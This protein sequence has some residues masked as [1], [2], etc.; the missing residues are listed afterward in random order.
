MIYYP[1]E[2]VYGSR[3]TAV[4]FFMEGKNMERQNYI[5]LIRLKMEKVM[6]L[7]YSGGVLN[8]P[9]KLADFT[10]QVL[11][12]ADREYLLV[13]SVNIQCQPVALE[14]ISIGGIDSAIVSPREVF[15]H[16][17]MSNAA[18]IFLIHNHPSGE[19]RPSESDKAITERIRKA[20]ELLDIP[21]WDHVITGSKER[22]YSFKEQGEIFG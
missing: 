19:C 5:P 6:E 10:Q 4:P 12:D 3:V 7:P 15:K 22:Y 17:I 18:G 1:C 20:G 2:T 13:L 11:G 8:E 16:A 21:V 9:K 14:I